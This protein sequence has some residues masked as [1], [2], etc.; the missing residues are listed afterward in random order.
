MDLTGLGGALQN[1]VQKSRIRASS[2]FAQKCNKNQTN[3][4][5]LFGPRLPTVGNHHFL[6]EFNGVIHRIFTWIFNGFQ[7]AFRFYLLLFCSNLCGDS[8]GFSL[9]IST[10]CSA[11]GGARPAP[12]GAIAFFPPQRHILLYCMAITRGTLFPKAPHLSSGRF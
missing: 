1:F 6:T 9:F 3:I 4:Y 7:S 5:F 10:E 11:P 8:Y 2:Q 12:G